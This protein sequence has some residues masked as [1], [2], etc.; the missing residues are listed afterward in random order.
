[1][2]S[3]RKKALI[4]CSFAT[5]LLPAALLAAPQTAQVTKV[6]DQGQTHI[7]ADT[8]DG[9]IDAVISTRLATPVETE[10]SGVTRCS[11]GRTSCSLVNSLSITVG[12]NAVSIPDRATI[13]LSD[14]NDGRIIRLS[15]DHYELMLAGGDAAVAYK[16]HLFF[17]KNM[18][19]RMDIWSSEANEIQ[20]STTYKDVSKAF[21]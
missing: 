10:S 20:Q 3:L 4:G 9:R 15:A 18:V 19:T 12:K 2:P 1:M 16:A 17:N 21:R 8:I 13:L 5:V 6:A 11:G 7:V 14:V